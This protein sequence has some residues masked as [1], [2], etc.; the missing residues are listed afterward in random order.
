M[1]RKL[2]ARDKI[3]TKYSRDGLTEQNLIDKSE[4]VVS[5][6][7]TDFELKRG[8]NIITGEKAAPYN[9]LADTPKSK[10]FAQAKEEVFNSRASH[11]KRKMIYKDTEDKYS[12]TSTN[13]RD[14]KRQNESQQGTSDK[15]IRYRYND[16]P[17][18]EH[19]RQEPK[20]NNFKKRQRMAVAKEQMK[21]G[22]LRTEQS[23]LKF[24]ED[25]GQ[26][27]FSKGR[28]NPHTDKIVNSGLQFEDTEDEI[29][30]SDDAAKATH[31]AV[32]HTASK[33]AKNTKGT[34]KQ[35]KQRLLFEK[36][37]RIT[38]DDIQEVMSTLQGRQ[39][40]AD[41]S[42]AVS[43]A[44]ENSVGNKVLEKSRS[45][46]TAEKKADKAMEKLKRAESRQPTHNVL[47]T[48]RVYDDKSG[49]AKT[50]LH[51][52]NEKKPPSNPHFIIEAPKK[53]IG[54]GM[55][56]AVSKAHQKLYQS[57]HDNSAVQAAHRTELVAETGIRQSA[58]YAV[59]RH[60]DKPYRLQ[61]KVDRLKH[62][63]DRANRRLLFEKVKHENPDLQK[64]LNKKLQQKRY[65]KKNYQKQMRKQAQKKTAKKVAEKAVK[66]LKELVTVKN[67]AYAVL[68]L[69]AIVLIIV[70]CS[71][72]ASVITSMI[73]G[74]GDEYVSSNEEVGNVVTAWDDMENSIQSQIDNAERNF[75]DYD[76]YVYMVETARADRQKLLAYLST[77]HHSIVYADCQTEVQ[78]LFNQIYELS[79]TEYI[80]GD[81]KE[82]DI[83]L[84]VNSLDDIIDRSLT[85]D[86]ERQAYGV[87]LEIFQN[88]EDYNNIINR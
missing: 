88:S 37:Q 62:K 74:F 69:I 4:R 35:K 70:F 75:T 49:K 64:K 81:Y 80:D 6:K 68:A 31:T 9:V 13:T 41:S 73:G 76:N 27:K 7:K 19:I 50:R 44:P 36:S 40:T 23:N 63:V 55:E 39:D 38:S 34:L 10:A 45:Y 52:E 87:Y 48:E 78:D 51:F 3:V 77:K 11:N 86:E 85:T 29:A 83:K 30:L 84:H 82:L 16:K 43:F 59:K 22:T 21:P 54:V 25:K 71:L 67:K 53:V 79:F 1:S 5:D 18:Q 17:K 2:Q 56:A 47:K 32:F 14:T 8:F 46:L 42:G 72:F 57:E 66:I 12:S 20:A 24:T 33:V 28:E 26:L 65:I 60:K 15:P 58:R 61:R